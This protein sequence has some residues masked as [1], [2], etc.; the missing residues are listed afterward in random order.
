MTP[1][2]HQAARKSDQWRTWGL[3]EIVI[4]EEGAGDAAPSKLAGNMKH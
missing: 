4:W 1:S 3:A 2:M